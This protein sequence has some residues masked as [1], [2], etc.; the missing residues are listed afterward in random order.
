[1]RTR[2]LLAA[3]VLSAIPAALPAGETFDY[4]RHLEVAPK[5]PGAWGGRFTPL[6]GEGPAVGLAVAADWWD[7]PGDPRVGDEK[8][9]AMEG[10]LFEVRRGEGPWVALPA[11][12]RDTRLCA[13]TEAP[14]DAKDLLGAVPAGEWGV[15]QKAGGAYPH[16]VRIEFTLRGDPLLVKDLRVVSLALPDLDPK[17]VVGRPHHPDRQGNP[18]LKGGAPVKAVVTVQNCGARKSKATDVDLVAAPPG[19]RQ[20]KRIAFGQC[21]ALEPGKSVEVVLEGRIPEE[22][23]VTGGA[24]EIVAVVNPRNTEREVETW[25]NAL[26]RAFRLDVPPPKDP[27][28]GDLRDR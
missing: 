15:R 11:C 28:P 3:A 14:A 17:P 2:S 8:K 7:G 18:V 21:E 5:G 24:W 22:L 10:I 19:Q 16:R 12:A 25:N 20:G 6:A 26:A 27:L 23:A 13:R 1:M 9:S 4:L